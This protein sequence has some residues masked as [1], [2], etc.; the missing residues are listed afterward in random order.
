MRTSNYSDEFKRDAV[1]QIR[2]R[3]I[4]T[5]LHAVDAQ[6]NASSRWPGPRWSTRSGASSSTA[7]IS[8]RCSLS[9]TCSWSEEG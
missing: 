2:V 7:P 8:S 9:P 1:Q 4:G 6:N 5:L 3:G